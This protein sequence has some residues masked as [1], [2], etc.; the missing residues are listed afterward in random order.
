M[1][2]Y[3]GTGDLI[4][5]GRG[6]T[7]GGIPVAH[8]TTGNQYYYQRGV[9]M[10]PSEAL[11]ELLQGLGR[12]GLGEKDAEIE[13]IGGTGVVQVKIR[14]R[15]PT[16]R[17]IEKLGGTIPV[18]PSYVLFPATHVLGFSA[19]RPAPAR[20][21]VIPKS[22]LRGRGRGVNIGVVDLGFFDPGKAGHPVWA[23]RGVV[24]DQTMDLPDP[25]LD[26]YPYVGHGNAIVG[27]LKQLAPEATV[28]TST[29]ESQ[30]SD[31][32][33]G[34]TDRRLGE[35]IERLLSCRRI[36]I[37][38]IPFG[39]S[40]RLGSM[41]VTESVLD[42][43]LGSTLVFASAGNEGLDPTM[44][45]AVDPE[46]VGT[47]AWKG[48]ASDLGWLTK[49]CRTVA[50]PLKAL[51]SL[52]LADW[53]NQGIAVQLGAAGIAVPAP[54]VK[55]TFKIR[56]GS[57]DKPQAIRSA[58]FN[59]WALFTGTSFAAAVAAGCVAGEVGGNSCPTPEVLGA[60]ISR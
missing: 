52:D 7:I 56:P 28:Y 34:T 1:G 45:P 44:Y 59:G 25:R 24:L 37:L 20:P 3:E 43:Y 9:L 8:S 40:T 49:V 14:T 35:A 21:S 23:T 18:E 30:K 36:H 58:R 53:S 6:S 54:F 10:V 17:L 60:A 55:G 29:V 39:G 16:D 12:L 11:N 47:G 51:G 2:A 26:H 50:S 27:I 19:R 57:L 42:P 5:G 33:G 31:A 22:P 38:V 32:P 41:P 48:S 46:V 4:K 13:P 15:V